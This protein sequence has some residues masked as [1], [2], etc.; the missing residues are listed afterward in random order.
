MINVNKLL[1]DTR[2]RSPNRLRVLDDVPVHAARRCGQFWMRIN[3]DS[4]RYAEF[5]RAADEKVRKLNSEAPRHEK[6]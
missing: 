1:H 4:T 2:Y 6:Q 5:I 3:V